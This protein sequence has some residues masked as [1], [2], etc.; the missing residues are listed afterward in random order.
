MPA[1][2]GRR[3]RRRPSSARTWPFNQVSKFTHSDAWYYGHNFTKNKRSIPVLIIAQIFAIMPLYGIRTPNAAQLKFV[4]MSGRMLH[5]VLVSGAVAV[6]TIMSIIWCASGPVS[7]ARL[8]SVL[9]VPSMKL[10][11]LG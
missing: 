5:S 8:G 9:L 11:M 2:G 10:E 7:V 3:G 4:W 6:M 1:G